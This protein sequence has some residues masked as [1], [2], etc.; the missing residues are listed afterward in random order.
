VLNRYKMYL[1]ARLGNTET[2]IAD[3][4]RFF[5]IRGGDATYLP[6][7]YTMYGTILKNAGRTHEA[8]E[9]YEKA[10]ALNPDLLETYDEAVSMARSIDDYNLGARYYERM[11]EVKKRMDEDKYNND[12][13]VDINTLGNLYYQAGTLTTVEKHP[14]LVDALMAE[15]AWEG[16]LIADIDTLNADSLRS[17][18]EYFSAGYR[19]YNLLRAESLFSELVELAPESYTGYYY[20]AR[21]NNA[22]H[23]GNDGIQNGIPGEHYSKTVSVIDARDEETPMSSMMQRALK[24]GLG[25]LAYYHYMKDDTENAVKYATRLLELDPENANA[26]AILEDI[27]SRK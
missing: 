9:Q 2:G 23:P 10:I 27:K 26:K 3:A 15:Q 5:A 22:L 13:L 4:E 14:E 11:L 24:E 16:R 8:I 20:L 6:M 18:K 19:K 12:R 21:T 25:Y 1:D 7:D 17:D